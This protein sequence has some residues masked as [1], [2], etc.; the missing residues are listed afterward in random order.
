MAEPI[1]VGEP[2]GGNKRVLK[3]AGAGA[4]LLLAIVVLPGLLFGGDDG[5][6]EDPFASPATTGGA[7]PTTTAPGQA[8]PPPQ[9]TFEPFSNHNPF[10]P[11]AATELPAEEAPPAQGTTSTIPTDDGSGGF[12]IDD[13]GFD[14]GS[15]DG[16]FDGGDGG[17]GG[18]TPTTQ[19]PPPPRQPDRVG[20]LEVF[21]DPGG[22]VVATVRVN[23]TT[24]QVADGDEFATSYRVLDLDI[25]TRCGQ[26]LFGDD[27]FGLCEGDEALK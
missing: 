11:L 19:P 7:A 12:P 18:S 17:D 24:Y 9:E 13:G 27:R 23:D 3:L 4:A 2:S 8:G 5:T 1:S 15:D 21:T 14:G 26:F 25:R 10:T 20:L 22:Q 6:V 16:G